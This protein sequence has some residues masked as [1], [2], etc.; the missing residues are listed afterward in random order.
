MIQKHQ[1]I[2]QGIQSQAI[3]Q[4]V[5]NSLSQLDGIYDLQLDVQTGQLTFMAKED[6][7][8]LNQLSQLIHDIEPQ[9]HIER[10]KPHGQSYEWQLKGLSCANCAQ[11]VEDA[12]GQLEGVHDS[13]VN[14]MTESFTFT[15]EANQQKTDL[16]RIYKKI[17]SLEP[18]LTIRDK[19]TGRVINNE[20][21]KEKETRNESQHTFR[22]QS[23][24]DKTIFLTGLRIAL[25]LILLLLA[26]FAGLGET[27]QLLLFVFAYIIVGYDVLLQAIK[28]LFNGQWFDESFLMSIATLSAFY[29]QE[30]PEAVAVMLFYQLGEL[31]QSVAVGKSRQSISDLMDIQA[32]VANLWK[33]GKSQPV[34]PSQVELGDTLLIRPGEKVP[35]DGRVIKGQSTVD[36]SALTGESVPR[37]VGLDDEI[38]SGFINGQGLLYMEVEKEYADST[39]KKILD[40]VEHA[41]HRKAPTE[42]FISKFARWYTP[43]VVGAA[44]ILA[45]LMPLIIPGAQFHD[46]IYRAC[47]FLVISCPCALVVSI[48]VSIFGGIGLASKKGILIKGGNYLEALT[49]VDTV[50]FDKT[51]TLT[52]GNF[53]V[54]AIHPQEEWTADQLLFWAAYAEAHSNHPIGQSIVSAYGKNIEAS[55]ISDYNEIAGH[56]IQVKVDGHELLAGNGRLMDRFNINYQAVKEA[57]TVVYLAK[58]SS[59]MGYLLIADEIKEDAHITAQALKK[60]G[61][62]HLVMLTGDSAN[63]AQAIGQE[64]DL[65]EVYAE[66]LPDDKVKI[67]EKLISQEN[68]GKRTVFVGDGINDT[69]VIARAD[70]G[71]AMG[72]MGSDAAI[73]AADVVLMDDQPSKVAQ[74]IDVAHET[75]RIVWQNI[76]LILA[77]K[78]LFLILGAVGM[79][80]MWGAVFADV[81]LTV[82]SVLNAMRILKK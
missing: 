74:A 10:M 43:L 2:I 26:L 23:L 1:W 57:G 35:L 6:Q 15:L 63:I 13:D 29:I 20:E 48:P 59:Y 5:E 18:Q 41:S 62:K 4:Q 73:E 32:E 64:L 80:S 3:A 66:L 49:A 12:V 77:V 44:A 31:F 11:K 68:E 67:L 69:A 21:R 58:D 72:A 56:G 61:V 65:D 16:K 42:K 39:V 14:F 27:G 37:S 51:G 60:Q 38:L 71:F 24:M 78:G 45:F 33:D 8:L 75:S 17:M 76:I 79:A 47:V 82:I 52:E 30:Y 36:T 81:G 34:D 7:A 46:W 25:A 22:F 53:E 28:N 9:S 54:T 19:K 50:V 70:I 40:M 55:K